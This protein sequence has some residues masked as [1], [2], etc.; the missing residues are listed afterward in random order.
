VEALGIV[1]GAVVG[2]GASFWLGYRVGV[3]C[4][5]LHGNWY[6][7]ASGVGLLVSTAFTALGVWCAWSWMWVGGIAAMG[8]SLRGLRHG[9]DRSPDAWRWRRAADGERR[10][11]A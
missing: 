8:G 7:V 4:R 5:D 11:S 6:W 3:R 9:L 2:V 1:A 10:G